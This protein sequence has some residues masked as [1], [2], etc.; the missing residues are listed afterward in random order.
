[1]REISAMRA[2]GDLMKRSVRTVMQ[3]C[4]VVLAVIAPAGGAMAQTQ[5]NMKLTN[6]GGNVLAGIYVGPYYATINNTPNVPIIC[7]DFTD[8]TYVGESWTANVTTVA[9]GDP[10]WISQRQGLS[11]T[12]QSADYAEVAFLAE[13][14]MNPATT[15]QKSQADCAGDIQFAIWNIFDPGPPLSLLS[16]NDWINA[17]AWL[18]AATTAYADKE[19]S[20]SLYSNVL[21]YSPAG[22]GP[23]QEFIMV[24]TPEPGLASLLSVDLLTL[25]GVVFLMHRRSKK[26]TLGLS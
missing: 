22:G 24:Q 2:K 16:G 6:P 17:N 21:V 20:P 7:D 3:T 26:R 8:E 11:S 12:A 15:C 4:V 14:L 19:I 1:M 10:T 18:N 13:Q 5:A 23:P 9:S 25:A